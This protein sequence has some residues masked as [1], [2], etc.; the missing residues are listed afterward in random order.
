M[1]DKN[2][3]EKR[4]CSVIEYILGKGE[5]AG[6]QHYLP[7]PQYFQKVFFRRIEKPWDCV[8]KGKIK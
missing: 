6:Y 4:Y 1:E 2:L 5:N 7:F 3:K 8:V